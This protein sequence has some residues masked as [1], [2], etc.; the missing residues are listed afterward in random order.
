MHSKEQL[1]TH[2]HTHK[3]TLYHCNG[4][5]CF[6]YL[7]LFSISEDVFRSALLTQYDHNAHQHRDDDLRPEPHGKHK[8]LAA[9]GPC[10]AAVT[11]VADVDGEGVGTCKRWDP[12]VGN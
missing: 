4:I 7:S 1:N 2:T 10:T 12:I 11:T 5:H 9:A 3:A 8:P 6:L